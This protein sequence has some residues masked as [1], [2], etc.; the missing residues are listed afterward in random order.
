[1][2]EY[3]RCVRLLP[4]GTALAAR[5]GD[6]AGKICGEWFSPATNGESPGVEP[7]TWVRY[8]GW[9]ERARS[10]GEN[11]G[12]GA[13]VSGGLREL[14]GRGGEQSN[15][16]SQ[17]WGQDSNDVGERAKLF[18]QDHNDRQTYRAAA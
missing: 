15:E 16:P 2:P 11:Q 4:M 10:R 13:G 7:R 12:I 6:W 17:R 5:R 18:R 1:F 9:A 3:R 14:A 8:G